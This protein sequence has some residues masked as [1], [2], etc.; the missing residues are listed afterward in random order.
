MKK[1]AV[2]Y[3]DYEY[4]GNFVETT[5]KY[6]ILKAKI[7]SIVQEDPDT[8]HFDIDFKERRGNHRPDITKMK[9]RSS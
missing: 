9:F 2:I 7:K 6:N 4:E 3:I 5:E 1:R 8:D